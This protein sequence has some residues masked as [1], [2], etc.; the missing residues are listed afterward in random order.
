MKAFRVT[1][2][3]FFCYWEPGCRSPQ[4]KLIVW[5]PKGDVPRDGG[6]PQTTHK[7]LMNTGDYNRKCP[8]RWPLYD[9]GRKR[10]SCIFISTE[11]LYFGSAEYC[12]DAGRGNDTRFFKRKCLEDHLEKRVP[13]CH[14]SIRSMKEEFSSIFFTAVFSVPGTVLGKWQALTKYLLNK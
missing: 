5:S 4:E 2:F 7:Q 13:V 3:S 10:K 8:N 11:R 12:W 9:E 6:V 14:K 1:F